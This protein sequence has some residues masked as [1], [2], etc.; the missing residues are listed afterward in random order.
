MR[1]FV[2]FGFA[3]SVATLLACSSGGQ[4]PTDENLGNDAASNDVGFQPDLGTGGDTDFNITQLSL[5][6]PNAVV[7]ID[8][9]TGTPVAGTATFK[10][11]Q[12][13]GDKEVDV[14]DKTTFSVDDTTLGSFAGN[15]FTSATALP[16]GV[17]GKSTIV[18]GQPGN[19]LA[20]VTVIALRVSGD[21][22]DF[23]FSVPYLKDPDP[24]KDILKFGTKIKQ[25]DVGILMDTTQSMG[26]EIANLLDSLSTKIVPGLKTAIPNVGYAVAHF[27]DFP[28][29]PF[30]Y[31]GSA[32]GALNKPYELFQGVTTFESATKSAV[33]LLKVYNGGAFPEAQYEA[34]Y[35]LLTGEG[36]SWTAAVAGSIPKHVVKSGTYGG[37]DWRPG[38]LPVVVQITDASWFEKTTYSTGTAG[39]LSPHSHTEV[40]SAYD[41]NK[42]K[43]VGIHSLV[44]KSDG[45]MD[46]PCTNY[47]NVTCDSARGYQQ[48]I[49]MAQ[50]TGSVLD[51]S[52][53]KGACG[54]GKCCTGI[55][56][57]AQDPVGGKCPLVYLANPNGT[58][59]AEGIV[60]AIEA[61]SVGSAFDVTAIKSNDPSNM[62]WTGAAVDATKFIDKIRAMKEG[63]SASGCAARA[64]KDADGDGVED[65]F[66]AVTVGEP[67]CFEVIPKKNDFVTPA[68]NAPQFFKAFIDVVGM[69]G[70]V[71]LDRRDV[72]FLV[73][74]KEQGP[75]K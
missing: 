20:N 4:N 26:E 5:Q 40:V 38:S 49:K 28:V 32:G 59:V 16:P 24:A 67:V 27:E 73:P 72:L 36:F 42:A 10:A 47:A 51:P 23:F 25:V 29:S 12:L 11:I 68:T 41:T 17:Y 22:K 37:A 2:R 48:A 21:K 52:A 70:A 53:F 55:A 62:D 19:G 31:D 1:R 8:L 46:T 71:K 6:P 9:T 57:A 75:A 69:P 65:T 39:K 56:G 66:V 33:E 13:Q 63:D 14:S 74:P 7:K 60:G 15:V 3:C 64:V 45:T 35:Q 18:H 30:G 58:G 50:D 43:F 44:K 54:A 34:Q 61:I